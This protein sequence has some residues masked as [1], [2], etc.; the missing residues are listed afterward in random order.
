MALR[1]ESG[2]GKRRNHAVTEAIVM[3]PKLEEAFGLVEKS[4]V[5]MKIYFAFF[6]IHRK[7]DQKQFASTKSKLEVK[8]SLD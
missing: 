1:I 7:K 4:I 8:S 5:G 2:T 6:K 3:K